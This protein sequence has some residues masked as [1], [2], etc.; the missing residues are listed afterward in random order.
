MKVFIKQHD[1][2]AGKWIY[3][4]YYNAWKHLGYE[5][6]YYNSLEELINENNY[7][8]M[9]LDSCI[10]EKNISILQKAK[11]VFYMCNQII[12]ST[13]GDCILILFL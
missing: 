1:L 5:P 11:K 2:H 4:G 6:H 7:L 9:T 13:L 12:L 10:T 8:L 3:E